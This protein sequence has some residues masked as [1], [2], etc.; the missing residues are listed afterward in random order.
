MKITYV[1]LYRWVGSDTCLVSNFPP[2]RRS[3]TFHG[4][5]CCEATSKFWFLTGYSIQL[6]IPGLHNRVNW[7]PLEKNK[8]TVITIFED[9][10]NQWSCRRRIGHLSLLCLFDDKGKIIA[11]KISAD[12]SSFRIYKALSHNV[13]HLILTMSLQSVL[14]LHTVIDPF[15]SWEIQ[16][17]RIYVIFPRTCSW[18]VIILG[19]HLWKIES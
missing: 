6:R 16:G 17:Q 11:L 7:N 1:T 15:E 8:K 3:Q 2:L 10:K 4:I 12:T 18:Y 13:F 5:C 14:I 19:S 9:F